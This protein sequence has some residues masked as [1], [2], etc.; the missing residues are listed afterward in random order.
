[1]VLVS[2][3]E[4]IYKQARHERTQE[5]FKLFRSSIEGRLDEAIKMAASCGNNSVYFNVLFISY[6]IYDPEFLAKTIQMLYEQAGFAVNY[7][8]TD[9]EIIF[10]VSW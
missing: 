7:R 2:E 3:I 5:D 10:E 8:I 1:M 4:K 9:Y 6:S